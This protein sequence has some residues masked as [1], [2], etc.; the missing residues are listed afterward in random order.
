MKLNRKLIADLSIWLTRVIPVLTLV[1]LILLW[2][3]YFRYLSLDDILSFTPDNLIIA[4]I[5]LMILFAVKSLIIFFPVTLLYLSVG[6]IYSPVSAILINLAG[7][8]ICLSVPYYLG[9]LSGQEILNKFKK[10]YP[11]LNRYLKPE[12]TNSW[13]YAY[14]LRIFNPLPGDI[15]SMLLGALGIPYKI[16]ITSSTVASIPYLISVTYLG[17]NIDKPNSPAF[18][19]SLIFTGIITIFSVV[20]YAIYKNIKEKKKAK[21]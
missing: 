3:T 4:F 11:K 17:V 6:T 7:I 5:V 18:I 10:R 2:F 14:V 15:R 19:I 21:L 1:I 12:K 9:K 13:I 20:A 16:Y 8:I